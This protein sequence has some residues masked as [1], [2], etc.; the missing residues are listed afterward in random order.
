MCGS[1]GSTSDGTPTFRTPLEVAMLQS[2]CLKTD[3]SFGALSSS[4]VRASGAASGKWAQASRSHPLFEKLP[5]STGFRVNTFEIVAEGG[6]CDSDR[7]FQAYYQQ[8]Q[9]PAERAS[10]AE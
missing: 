3:Q 5:S 6:A 8:Q 1:A 7:D 4:E 9:Y 2:Q 10:I